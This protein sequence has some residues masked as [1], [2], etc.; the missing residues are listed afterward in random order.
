MCTWQL[1][2]IRPHHLVKL[3]L[4]FLSLAVCLCISCILFCMCLCL[5]VCLYLYLYVCAFF[6]FLFEVFFSAF[7]ASFEL[8]ICRSAN[9]SLWAHNMTNFEFA[10]AVQKAKQKQTIFGIPNRARRP[11][12]QQRQWWQQW[13]RWPRQQQPQ[14]RRW[15]LHILYY[16]YIHANQPTNFHD[17][18]FAIVTSLSLI[19]VECLGDHVNICWL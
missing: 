1:Y 18:R 9:C 11:R 6:V 2:N 19:T 3:V 17:K 7:F 13:Q 5:C 16:D 10:A 14:Q 8:W 4:R 12:W 15:W